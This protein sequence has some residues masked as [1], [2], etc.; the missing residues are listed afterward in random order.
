MIVRSR[1]PDDTFP[2]GVT[3]VVADLNDERALRS[4]L[5]G[6]RA[7]L[8]MLTDATFDKEPKRSQATSLA[9]EAR[10]PL[11]TSSSP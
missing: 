5:T 10:G 1:R 6:V 11:R 7:A 2:S 8:R 9:I 3:Q 4:A